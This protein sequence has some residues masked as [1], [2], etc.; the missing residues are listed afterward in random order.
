MDRI[1]KILLIVPIFMMNMP[2]MVEAATDASVDAQ[3]IP[4]PPYAQHI[5]DKVKEI[6]PEYSESQQ[7]AG[8]IVDFCQ[9]MIKSPHVKAKTIVDGTTR[10]IL[11]CLHNVDQ[12][13]YS[14]LPTLVTNMIRDVEADLEYFKNPNIYSI[15]V[16][17]A[18][19]LNI[20]GEVPLQD[21][22]CKYSAI[23]SRGKYEQRRDLIASQ[24]E[25]DR[26]KDTFKNSSQQNNGR[27]MG[28]PVPTGFPGFPEK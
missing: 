25:I 3:N 20:S 5:V 14:N 24:I 6:L 17:V 1:I 28:D 11:E 26:L 8:Q 18:N 16:K 2:A 9:R 15:Q 7:I 4:P 23:A 12:S 10:V 19:D 21:P 13:E 27:I 22:L